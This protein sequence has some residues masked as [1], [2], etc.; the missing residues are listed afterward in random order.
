MRIGIFGG[1]F[2]PPHLGHLILAMEACGQLS[3]DRLLW[4]LTPAPPHKQTQPVTSI[5]TRIQLVLAAIENDS[6]FQL[7]L[8]E[9]GRPAPQYA[10]DT[11]RQLRVQNPGAELYYLMGGDSLRDLPD[12]HTPQELV[13]EC[14]GL[15]VM[16]RPDDDVDLTELEKQLPGLTAKVAFVDAPLLEISSRQVRQRIARGEPFRYY[17][18]PKVY[19]I[20]VK[21]GLYKQLE[22]D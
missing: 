2:D 1:T 20:I 17:L 16:R 9:I 11:V 5:E 21:Q 6:E 3:L 10:I 8:V 7:S 15:G 12:W 13:D 14:D 18:S 4:V 22:V 19:E